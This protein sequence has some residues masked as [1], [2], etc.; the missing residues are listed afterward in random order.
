MKA[1]LAGT[2]SLL[3]L[4]ACA[5]PAPPSQESVGRASVDRPDSGGLK[6]SSYLLDGP[7]PVLRFCLMS[8][9]GGRLESQWLPWGD[10]HVISVSV[11]RVADGRPL[12]VR[13]VT[14]FDWDAESRQEIQPGQVVCGMFPLN[15]RVEGLT[16]AREDSPLLLA[17]AYELIPLIPLGVG[18]SGTPRSAPIH[19]RTESATPPLLSERQLSEPVRWATGSHILPQRPRDRGATPFPSPSPTQ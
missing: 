5:L 19:L 12:K 6:V 9:S 14:S 1:L 13:R 4:M 8:D 2:A 11:T 7:E 17:W 3:C 10:W 18:S 16:R 15:E